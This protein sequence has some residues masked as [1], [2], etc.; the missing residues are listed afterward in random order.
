MGHLRGCQTCKG[1]YL[2]NGTRQDNQEPSD[3][4][5]HQNV[6]YFAIAIF[7]LA[8]DALGLVAY[9]WATVCAFPGQ[10]RRILEGVSQRALGVTQDRSFPS[11]HG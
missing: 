8:S 3:K 10:A 5:G 1:K 6:K 11:K 2:Y 9:A 4:V 7:H